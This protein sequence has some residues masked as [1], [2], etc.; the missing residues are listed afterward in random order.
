[1]EDERFRELLERVINFNWEEPRPSA[2][3]AEYEEQRGQLQDLWRASTDEAER[4][5]FRR[6]WRAPAPIEVRKEYREVIKPRL[7]FQFGLRRDFPE[8][9]FHSHQHPV[10]GGG[11]KTIRGSFVADGRKVQDD[12]RR[13]WELASAKK[14]DEAKRILLRLKMQFSY[15]LKK[16]EEQEPHSKGRERDERALRLMV[17][18]LEWLQN[19]LGR[20]K[21]CENPKCTTER[22]YFFR[23]YS[24]DRYCCRKCGL[25]A[26]ALRQAKRD[27]ESQK[28]P[29]DSPFTDKTRENMAIAAEKRWEK[30]RA[31][32]GKRKYER[33]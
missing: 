9:H 22:K 3:R 6:Q 4:A 16:A 31:S 11:T 17:E 15:R 5:T 26:K 12:L 27:A 23:D 20:L 21:V 1:M 29:K 28:P 33:S 19:R 18:T 24:N 32:K 25:K 13:V 14:H 10:V 8:W 7:K 30:Y 2:L